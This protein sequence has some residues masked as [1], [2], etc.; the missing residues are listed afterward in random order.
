MSTINQKIYCSLTDLSL[1]RQ[2]QAGLVEDEQQLIKTSAEEYI[3]SAFQTKLAGEGSLWILDYKSLRSIWEEKGKSF[4]SGFPAVVVLLEKQEAETLWHADFDENIFF[5]FLPLESITFRFICKKAF[6]QVKTRMQNFREKEL[7]QSLFLD[8][9][10]AK[11]LVDIESQRVVQSN[12]AAERLYGK[13][14]QDLVNQKLESLHPDN[15]NVL[16]HEID[17][18]LKG[19]ASFV[20]LN[21]STK[22][23]D[24]KNLKMFIS[25]A[26]SDER[27]MVF[28]DIDDI[29]EKERANQLYY[30]QSETLLNTLESI[31]DL[32]FSLNKDGDFTEYY[33]ADSGTSLPFSSDVFV[34]KNIYD[35]GFP[36]EVAQK[37]IQSIEYVAENDKPYQL[38]YFLD[39]FGAKLWYNAKIS[40]RKNAMGV[41]EGVTVLCRDITKEKKNEEILRHARDFYQTLLSDFPSM[42]WK[43][44]ISRKADYFNNTWLDFTGRK[45]EDELSTEWV[46]KLHFA[47]VNEFLEVLSIAYQYKQ[48]FQ[49]E[50]RLKHKSGD[51]R[52][53]LNVGRPFYNLEGK[54]AG[55]IGSCYDITERRQ[56]EEMLN[57]QKSAIESALEGIL[58]LKDD[59]KNYPVI[60]AN[61]E[62]IKLTDYTREQV[63]GNDFL[64][65]IGCP[66][67]NYVKE[68]ILTAL[69]NKQSYKGEIKCFSQNDQKESWRLLYIAP[70]MHKKN[71]SNHFVAILSDITESKLVEKT[72]RDKN[73][74]LRKTN[75]ELDSF[76]YSTSHELRSPLMSI[77][78]LLNL[79]EEESQNKGNDSYISMIRDSIAR[80]DKIIHDI[81]DYSRNSRIEVKHEVIDFR[82]IVETIFEKHQYEDNFEKVELVTDIKSDVPFL[83]DKKRVDVLINNLISNSLRFHNYEQ[84]KPFVQVK[85]KT[86]A[87]NVII[88]VEDNGSGIEKKHL[89]RLFDMFYRGTERSKG[90]GIGLYIVKEIVDKL[91]GNIQVHSQHNEGSC[92]TIELPNQLNKNFRVLTLG[93]DDE[94]NFQ[95]QY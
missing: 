51:Y 38:E 18:V 4:F 57:I 80:L 41:I 62:L 22:Q 32:L 35:V 9:L 55:F 2:V 19:E 28:I 73:R 33:H 89:P 23:G 91:N 24:V 10:H 3:D 61:R 90:S 21:L 81:I 59:N 40:P 74:E 6:N 17:N 15:F 7:Y 8:S 79:L 64:T 49:I 86:T 70:V 46:D 92:F 5:V 71:E 13:P 26:N 11:L 84:E 58:I 34:G 52:W 94:N 63:L 85:V 45:P 83:S 65:A 88:S 56:A 77:L 78:G 25:R 69:K 27:R 54:F 47:D 68:E 50:H 44:N 31:D 30:Q 14:R 39:A 42:I 29:T 60:Y 43:T 76:V 75:E 1:F 67:E 37:Y 95:S 93:S 72:L 12:D 87:A 53:V 48:S 82:D 66:V 36:L 20:K 16:W